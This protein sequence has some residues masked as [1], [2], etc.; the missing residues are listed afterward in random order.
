ELA[1]L[2]GLLEAAP[3]G[4]EDDRRRVDDMLAAARAPAVPRRGQVLQRRIRE[5]RAG[6]GLPGLAQRLGDRVAG[7]VA[8]LQQA[9]ARSPAAAREP[10]A[11]IFARELDSELLEPVDR[12]RRLARQQAD[13][14][15]VGGLV[16]ALPDVGA[17]LIRRVV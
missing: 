2:L 7:A 8:D 9:A 3:A 16:R 14:P 11:A 17:V 1:A 4:R 6:A 12:R 5:R 13:Q 15:P 10:V